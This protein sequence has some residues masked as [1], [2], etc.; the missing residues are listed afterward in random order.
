MLGG[1]DEGRGLDVGLRGFPKVWISV[2]VQPRD[3]FGR[4]IRPGEQAPALLFAM[5]VVLVEETS[6]V[7]LMPDAIPPV[8]GGR[9]ASGLI[10]VVI[11]VLLVTPV[12][13][14]LVAALQTLVLLVLAK[15]RAGVAETVQVVAYATAPCVLAGL[16][17]PALRAACTAYGAVL[18][19]VGI[20][21][22]HDLESRR[23][24]V[25]SVVPAVFV[26][27]YG[28]RGFAAVVAILRRW[29]II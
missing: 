27:G 24:M 10:A 3:F 26:F 25:A 9:Y 2:L 8:A 22:V 14:H 21:E 4:E 23:A 29:Y 11:A 17:I 28:F 6:R 15:G 18:L 12:A 19:T 1:S 20:S 16:P 5:A 13:L 7:A